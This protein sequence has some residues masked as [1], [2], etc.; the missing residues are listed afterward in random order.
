MFVSVETCCQVLFFLSLLGFLLNCFRDHGLIIG[1]AGFDPTCRQVET[2]NL[3][4]QLP[5][6]FP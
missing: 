5:E 1:R 6:T 4:S 3:T 2:S